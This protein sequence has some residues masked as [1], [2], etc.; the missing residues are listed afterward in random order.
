M[1]QKFITAPTFSN[2]YIICT[3]NNMNL[4]KIINDKKKDWTK[5]YYKKILQNNIRNQKNG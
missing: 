2:L 1:A 4:V 5:K 3:L